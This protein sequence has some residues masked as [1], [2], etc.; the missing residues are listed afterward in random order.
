MVLVVWLQVLELGRDSRTDEG[1]PCV[2]GK[3]WGSSE[4][5]DP[6]HQQ[7]KQSVRSVLDMKFSA[8]LLYICALLSVIRVSVGEMYT[9]LLNVKQAISVERKLIDHLRTYI[10]HELERLDDIRRWVT[11][12]FLIKEEIYWFP[13]FF[14]KESLWIKGLV[15]SKE[16][17]LQ[18]KWWCQWTILL[19][20]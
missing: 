12:P 16:K 5:T 13:N 9:S 17:S 2:R 4:Q 3:S 7:Q 15:R 14:S 18:G 8:G 11:W 1:D 6:S 10:D 20:L 19:A